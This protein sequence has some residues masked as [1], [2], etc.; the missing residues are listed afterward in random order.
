MNRF[1]HVVFAILLTAIPEMA[2]AYDFGYT[3]QGQTLYYNVVDGNAEVAGHANIVGELVIPEIVTDSNG[4]TYIVTAIGLNTFD[5]CNGITSVVF[6]PSLTLIHGGAFRQCQGL[7]SL[8]FPSTYSQL[9]LIEGAFQGCKSL[10]SVY[11][12]DSVVF[13]TSEYGGSIYNYGC[14]P[15][16]GCSGIQSFVVSEGNPQ[17]DSRN[18]CNAVIEKSTNTLLTGC[19]NTII[20]STVTAIGRYAFGGC[21]GLT[22]LTIPSSVVNIAV[23][24]YTFSGCSGLTSIEVES[25]NT[26]YDSRNNCNALIETATNRIILGCRNTIIPNTVN[27]IGDAAFLGCDIDS[28]SIPSSVT[29]IYPEAFSGC[30]RLHSISITS[31]VTS[32]SYRAFADCIGIASITIPNTIS[33]IGN[34]AFLHVNNIVYYGSVGGSP[35][36]A[37]TLNGY[38]EAGF[39]YTDSTKTILTGYYGNDSVVIIPDQVDSI[40]GYAFAGYTDIRSVT[41]GRNVTAIGPYAFYCDTNITEITSF[42]TE[43]PILSNYYSFDYDR[44]SNIPINI[45]CGSLSS[46]QSEW[47]C[48][49]NF[50]QSEEINYTYSFTAAD[51]AMGSISVLTEPTCMMPTAAIAAIPNANYHFISWNDGNCD[52]PRNVLIDRDTSLT[53]RFAIDTHTVTVVPNNTMWGAVTL[54]NGNNYAHGAPC[55]VQ[56]Y[57]YQGYSFVE[58]SNGVTSNPYAFPVMGDVELTAIFQEGYGID[59]VEGADFDVRVIDGYIVVDGCSGEEVRLYDASGKEIAIKKQEQLPLYFEVP[60]SGSYIVNMGSSHARKVVV[61][62]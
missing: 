50:I 28:I 20:P 43:A 3:Y 21:K 35:W 7:S 55:I 44:L 51:T 36:G 37:K 5:M 42:A 47:F 25:G 8:S 2:S 48:F 27:I 4:N 13:R 19:K 11:I 22:T 59:D 30:S 14:N 49:N 16:T 26:V 46:Y 17:L 39:V 23:A 10:T 60:V 15:F 9:T 45:P 12:P 24:G 53:A 62:R 57:A 54:S 40:G 32:I 29:T 38:L 41:I 56:A 6:P 18:N 34:H 52:N 58:W 61:I 31:S 33:S 1:L